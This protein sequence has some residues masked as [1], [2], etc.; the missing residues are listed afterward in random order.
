[1]SAAHTAPEFL[2]HAT[3][4]LDLYTGR[5]DNGARI[6]E[7]LTDPNDEDRDEDSAAVGARR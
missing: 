2:R 4:T 7:A 5:T 1:M 6:L 3:T